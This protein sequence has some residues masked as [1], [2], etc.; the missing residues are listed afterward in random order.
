[1]L[2]FHS[3]IEIA[4]VIPGFEKQGVGVS[5]GGKHDLT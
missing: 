1:M 2:P 3:Q 4:H 5:A